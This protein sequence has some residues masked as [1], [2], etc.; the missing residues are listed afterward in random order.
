MTPTQ[1]Y[2]TVVPPTPGEAA[3][4]AIRW[5]RRGFLGRLV[6]YPPPDA[7]TASRAGVRAMRPAAR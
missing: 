1:T 2:T 5:E 4:A 3:S 7:P 6:R